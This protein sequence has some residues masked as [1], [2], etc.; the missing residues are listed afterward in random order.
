[1]GEPADK[2]GGVSWLLL[3]SIGAALLLLLGPLLCCYFFQRYKGQGTSHSTTP[4]PRCAGA[5]NAVVHSTSRRNN[6]A[7]D[8]TEIRPEFS[9][10]ASPSRDTFETLE[11]HSAAQSALSALQRQADLRQASLASAQRL[12]EEIPVGTQ[13]VVAPEEIRVSTQPVIVLE[14]R[15]VL[16]EEIPPE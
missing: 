10:D 1:M 13:P 3:I 15:A 5:D 7:L 12:N 16:D 11:F 9:R 14:P 6:T 8:P 4:P 2:S